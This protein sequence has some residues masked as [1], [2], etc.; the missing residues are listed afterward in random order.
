MAYS[1]T[2]KLGVTYYLHKTKVTFRRNLIQK[3]VYYFAR[4]A[5]EKTIEEIPAEYLVV[6]R[7]YNCLP[8]LKRKDKDLMDRI[9]S[10][11][12]GSQ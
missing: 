3:I 2:N 7:S 8:V 9:K 12:Q 5:N 1:Y 6:E 4:N 10:F 11:T